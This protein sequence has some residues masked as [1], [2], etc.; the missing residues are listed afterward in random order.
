MRVLYRCTLKAILLL[1]FLQREGGYCYLNPS[2]G[3]IL[4]VIAVVDVIAIPP[5]RVRVCV[6]LCLMLVQVDVGQGV[7]ERE[8]QET[9]RR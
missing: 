9:S 6:R 4:V 3:C 1:L 7:T 2:D 5:P 8:A